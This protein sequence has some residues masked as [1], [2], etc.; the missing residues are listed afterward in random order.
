MNLERRDDDQWHLD[1]KV[2]IGI[3][4]VLLIQ[5]ASGL[6]F[7]SKLESRVYALEAFGQTHVQAQADRDDRQDKMAAEGGHA[8]SSRL[9]RID[10]KLDRLIE[11]RLGRK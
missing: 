4:V 10:E 11:G 9:D 3:I 7:L 1:R 2:P 8:L 6:W 5:G